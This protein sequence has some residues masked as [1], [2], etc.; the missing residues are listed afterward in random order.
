[1]KEKTKDKIGRYATGTLGGLAGLVL[2]DLNLGGIAGKLGA[3][4][5]AQGNILGYQGMA[6]LDLI[7]AKYFLMDLLGYDHTSLA[8]GKAAETIGIAQWATHGMEGLIANAS[9]AGATIESLLGTGGYIVPIAKA[10]ACVGVGALAGIGAYY[11]GK[12]AI[13]AGKKMYN[14]YKTS[15]KHRLN[16]SIST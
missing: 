4:L 8:M 10:A 2:S 13:K 6:K 11:A 1:M 12:Y 9:G 3:G 5:E 16:C 7:N 15:K 14:W